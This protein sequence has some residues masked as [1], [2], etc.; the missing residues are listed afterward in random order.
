MRYLIIFV[1]SIVLMSGCI[2]FDHKAT[3]DPK[4]QGSIQTGIVIQLENEKVLGFDLHDA[5]IDWSEEVY[6]ELQPLSDEW[7]TTLKVTHQAPEIYIDEY[8]VIYYPHP[9]DENEN[10][11]FH[12]PLKKSDKPHKNILLSGRDNGAWVYY[13]IEAG[14][15]ETQALIDFMKEKQPNF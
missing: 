9:T 11:Y 14:K 10:V 1:V 13:V 4:V 12:I 6:N 5:K 7:M 8:I 3:I 2:G 15:K